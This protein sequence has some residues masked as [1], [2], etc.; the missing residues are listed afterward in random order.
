MNSRF[1]NFIYYFGIHIL[2][3]CP[4]SCTCRGGN[5]PYS[6]VLFGEKSRENKKIY[7]KKIRQI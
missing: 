2:S 6:K 7:I 3:G 4:I 1:E 5:N